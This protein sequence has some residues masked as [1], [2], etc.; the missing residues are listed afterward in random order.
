M[1]RRRFGNSANR[2]GESLLEAFRRHVAIVAGMGFCVLVLGLAFWRGCASSSSADPLA[3]WGG[4]SETEWRKQREEKRKAERAEE[5]QQRQA[6]EAAKQ[7]KA[8]A[9][10]EKKAN[11]PGAFSTKNEEDESPQ[12]SK[13]KPKPPPLPELPAELAAWTD[14]DF[15]IARLSGDPKLVLAVEYRAKHPVDRAKDS[16]LFAGLLAPPITAA[17]LQ[18]D[19]GVERPSGARHPAPAAAKALLDA[20]AAGLAASQTPEARKALEGMVAGTAR[21]DDD[22]AAAEAALA[23]LAQHPSPEHE[24]ILL[25][26]LTAPQHLRPPGQ[27]TLSAAELQRMALAAVRSGATGRFRASLA[28]LIVEP[29]THPDLRRLLTPLILE[30]RPE[31]LE[32]HTILLGSDLVEPT[33]RAAI[34]RQFASYSTHALAQLLGIRPAEPPA[35]SDPSWPSEVARRLWNVR[36]ASSLEGQ[37]RAVKSLADRPQLMLLAS[38]IPLNVARAQVYRTL[39]LHWP[40]GPGAL[41]AA[42]LG[43]NV[44]PEPGLVVVIKSVRDQ[45]ASEYRADEG[46]PGSSDRTK[47]DLRQFLK[48]RQERRDRVRKDWEQ[49]GE[50]LVRAY[51]EQFFSAAQS[52]ETK[53]P[54]ASADEEDPVL[55][56]LLEVPPKTSPLA[57]Y[58]RQ[59]PDRHRQA[60]SGVNVDPLRV[61]YLR[62]EGK[63]RVDRV[64]GYYRRHLA[65]AQ[66]HQL[67][68]GVWLDDLDARAATERPRSIDIL[69]T[70]AKTRSDKL[71]SEDQLLV[72]EI[73]AVSIAQF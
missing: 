58:H 60:A 39:E 23:A 20:L 73:L 22:R 16:Q 31:N 18:D 33:A 72:V 5:Q 14:R 59:W 38:T 45:L 37:H 11:R 50:E 7:A 13:P 71:A 21:T 4:M 62:F 43:K 29:A 63:S 69:I 36:W 46:R 67:D 19:A 52:A 25:R 12:S 30:C 57:S 24:A 26:A 6:A 55:G 35:S 51:C 56:R 64:L 41:R 68:D 34:E 44:L 32:A 3:K 53:P 8:A 40:D 27:G 42:G 61:D 9:R 1:A 48:T 10:A 15:Q 66:V 2:V 47:G 65:A 28:S 54:P 17:L 49:M 70:A